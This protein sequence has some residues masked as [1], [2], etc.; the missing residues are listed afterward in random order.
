[1]PMGIGPRNCVGLKLAKLLMKMA[2]VS[3]LKKHRFTRTHL[4]EDTL[5]TEC[6]S[7]TLSIASKVFVGLQPRK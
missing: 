1:M 4:T 2:L 3:L 7:V 5:H 6:Y